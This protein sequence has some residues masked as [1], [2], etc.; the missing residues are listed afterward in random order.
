MEL[1]SK[2]CD[3]CSLLW[4]FRIRYPLCVPPAR[5]PHFHPSLVVKD[6]DERVGRHERARRRVQG[7]KVVYALGYFAHALGSWL[8]LGCSS[9]LSRQFARSPGRKTEPSTNG[10]NHSC[11]CRRTGD[12]DGSGKLLL[13]RWTESSLFS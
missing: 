13:R 10:G 7:G 11:E 9:Q 1:N 8:G 5:L 6:A 12:D 2:H 4:M 3:R